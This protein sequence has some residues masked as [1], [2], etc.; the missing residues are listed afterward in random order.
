MRHRSDS[1]SVGQPEIVYGSKLFL[2]LSLTNADLRQT[3][4]CND[5]FF[6]DRP[7]VRADT[8]VRFTVPRY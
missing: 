6:G 8:R 7:L 1:P 4:H 3:V 5:L 2:Y